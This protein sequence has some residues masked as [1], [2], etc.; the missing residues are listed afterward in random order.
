[1]AVS[2]PVCDFDWPAPDFTLPGLE[3]ATR[4]VLELCGGEASEVVSDG[5]VPVTDR[6]YRLDPARVVSLVGMEIPAETQ[7]A[8]LRGRVR[9]QRLTFK[10]S[11]ESAEW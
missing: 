2:P 10:L 5:A 11:I 1:M 6:A 4:M 3:A 9:E 8:T 7:R